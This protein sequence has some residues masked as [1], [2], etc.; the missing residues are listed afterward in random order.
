MPSLHDKLA[1]Q[2]RMEEEL[3][4]LAKIQEEET[5]EPVQ[6][7]KRKSKVEVKLGR[8]KK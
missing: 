1:E 8:R 7:L 6:P 4:E 3:A 2:E 5:D